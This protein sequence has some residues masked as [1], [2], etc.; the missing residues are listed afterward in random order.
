MC[1]QVLWK[2]VILGY[3]AFMGYHYLKQMDEL[4]LKASKDWIV[5]NN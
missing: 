5:G 3:F 4:N 1:P 2:L